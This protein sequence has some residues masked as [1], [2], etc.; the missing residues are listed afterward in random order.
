VGF[1][2]YVGSPMKPTVLRVCPAD[3]VPCCCSG[4]QL[5]LLLLSLHR[6]SVKVWWDI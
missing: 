6:V 3:S 5:L 1:Y 2:S 4:S